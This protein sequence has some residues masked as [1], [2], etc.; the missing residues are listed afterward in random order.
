MQRETEKIDGER[1]KEDIYY[2]LQNGE[3]VEV[4]E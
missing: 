2:K 4:E 1:I 3:F